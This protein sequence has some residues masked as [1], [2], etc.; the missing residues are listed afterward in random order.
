MVI[1]KIIHQLWIG[2]HPAPTT[3]MR[4]WKDKHPDYEYILWNED[5]MKKRNFVSSCPASIAVSPEWCGK[6]DIYRWEILYQYGGIFIDADAICIEPLDEFFMDTDGFASYENEYTRKGL[7]AVGTMGFQKNHPLCK[8]AVDWC[9]ANSELIRTHRAWQTTGP[10]MVTRL[11]NSGKYPNIVLY[12]SYTFLPHHYTGK[13]YEGHGKVYAYQEWGSTK[14]NYHLMNSISLP[15]ILLPPPPEKWVSVLITSYNTP[16]NYI[17]ETLHSIKYQNGY[18]GIELVWVDDGSN[19]EHTASLEK[20]LKEFETTTRFTKV[21]YKKCAQNRGLRFCLNEGLLLCS[22]EIVLRMDSDD[23]MTPE[24]IN[25]QMAYMDSHPAVVICGANIQMFSAPPAQPRQM[26]QRTNH[27]TILTKSQ[28]MATATPSLWFINHP[29]VCFRK[30][31]ILDIGNYNAEIERPLGNL[32]EDYELM[33]KILNRYG[34]IHNISDVLLFY[35]IHE[36][37]LTHPKR[38][39]MTPDILQKRNH[40]IRGIF[41]GP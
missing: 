14:Q 4:T 34:E 12:P 24:R 2:P 25:I 41:S 10:T 39:I 19:G 22:H 15:S 18:F 29:T 3:F 31:A 1:P 27:P 6:T 33:L 13:K 11:V 26:L 35:R 21:V 30:S 8:E 20:A 37:Q 28:F 40:M 9:R 23:I 32:M 36:N 17:E 16:A 38:N 5:E 7:V